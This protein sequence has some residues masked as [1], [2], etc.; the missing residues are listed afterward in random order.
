M[1][2]Q[3]QCVTAKAELRAQMRARRAAMSRN[4][5]GA[6]S[7]AIHARLEPWHVYA[8][9]TTLCTY[10]EKGNEVATRPLIQRAF[11]RNVDV[12]VPVLAG[13]PRAPGIRMRWS[14]ITGLEHLTPG[15]FGVDEP[16]NELLDLVEPPSNGVVLVPGLA[17]TPAGARLGRGGGHFDRFLASF[18]GVAIGLAYDFQIFEIIPQEKHDVPVQHIVTPAHTY[19]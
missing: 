19:S 4:E 17:F 14:R 11:D 10:I 9:S 2:D 13:A 18:P 6:L 5:V 1:G 7:A 16:P 8:A 12:L 15:P 3:S